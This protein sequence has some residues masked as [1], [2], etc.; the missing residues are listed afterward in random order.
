MLL[1]LEQ[2]KAKLQDMNIAAVAR[3]TGLTKQAIHYIVNGERTNPSYETI[4]AL[5]KYLNSRG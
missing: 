4:K 5:S 3:K 1:T 2:I